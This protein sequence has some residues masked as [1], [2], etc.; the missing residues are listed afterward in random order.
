M[1]G[2]QI[3]GGRVVVI[4][5]FSVRPSKEWE[6][7]E[8]KIGVAGFGLQGEWLNRGETLS[9]FGS[10]SPIEK[11]EESVAKRPKFWSS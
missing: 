7:V 11:T 4:R 8:S 10:D 9:W 3:N 5:V 2:L 1:S 6:W